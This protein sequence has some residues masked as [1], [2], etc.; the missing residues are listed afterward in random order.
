M[1]TTPVTPLHRRFSRAIPAFAAIGG[2]GFLRTDPEAIS[3]A[4]QNTEGFHRRILGI[5]YPVST[6]QVQSLVNEAARYRVPLYPV[7]L[8]RNWGFGSGL[9]FR[10]D[11]L[12]VNLSGMNRIRNAGQISVASHIAVV[13]P[14]VTQ[15]M[16]HNHLREHQLPLT[17]NVTASGAETSVLGNALDRG[18]GFFSLKVEDLSGLEVVLANGEILRTGYGGYHPEAVALHEYKWG[19]GPWLDG[20]F[21]QGNFGIVTCAGFRLVPKRPVQITVIAK[22]RRQSDLGRFLEALT[23]LH[24]DRVIESVVRIG[25]AHRAKIVFGSLITKFFEEAGHQNPVGMALDLLRTE[26]MMHWTGFFLLSGTQARVDLGIAEVR[27]ALASFVEVSILKDPSAEPPSQSAID[28]AMAP[29]RQYTFGYPSDA[30]LPSVTWSATH[31]IAPRPDRLEAQDGGVLFCNPAIPATAAWV[32][33]LVAEADAVALKWNC[34]VCMTLNLSASNLIIAIINVP[35]DK[36]KPDEVDQAHRFTFDLLERLARRGIFPYRSDM[37]SLRRIQDPSNCYWQ[38]CARIK[39]ALDPYDIIAPG[40]YNLPLQ[41]H[42]LAHP[43][44]RSESEGE[45]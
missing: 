43:R 37:E 30:A 24:R 38:T 12:I 39:A 42:A 21:S 6:Q 16:L 32:N 19:L 45:I 10:D 13:E 5:C 36:R 18:L 29:L 27:E 23:Q 44:Q 9:P 40:R 28:Q 35:F 15:A 2:E 31:E 8:G 4:S 3:P 26:N 20:L 34:E 41:P 17:F 11:A 25:N 14:G 22:L 1:H 7:S 33:Y